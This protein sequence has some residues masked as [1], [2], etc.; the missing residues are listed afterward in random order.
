[1]GG[2]I[3]RDGRE[4]YFF[5]YDEWEWKVYLSIRKDRVFGPRLKKQRVTFILI[6][7][8]LPYMLY[9]RLKHQY[10]GH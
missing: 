4:D 8:K 6:A 2:L 10:K 7:A 1:M 5:F 3:F 9:T